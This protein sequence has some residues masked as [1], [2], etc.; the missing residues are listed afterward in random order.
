MALHLTNRHRGFICHFPRP[1]AARA[2]HSHFLRR[3]TQ[4]QMP[5]TRTLR[6]I[7]IGYPNAQPY[8]G[9]EKFMQYQPTISDS[10]KKI[11]V[12]TVNVRMSWFCS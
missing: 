11:A 3:N 12:M 5:H 7:T 4:K 10:G 8:Y 1:S 2:A 6:A 9:M